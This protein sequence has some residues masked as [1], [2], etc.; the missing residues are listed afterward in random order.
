MKLRE[1]SKGMRVR[2]CKE[3]S[4]VAVSRNVLHITDDIGDYSELV[5]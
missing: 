1:R 5:S 3:L 2:C 4:I